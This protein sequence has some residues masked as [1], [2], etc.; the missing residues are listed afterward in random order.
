MPFGNRTGP[1]GV[2]PMT[3]RAAG[4]CAGHG[5]PGSTNL[6]PGRGFGDGFGRGRGLRGRGGARRGWRHMFWATGLPG[7]MRCA[8]AGDAPVATPNPEMEKQFVQQRADFLQ[9]QMDAIQKRLSALAS[10][11]A[12]KE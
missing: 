1:V 10:R 6:V 11:E 2:G 12:P 3:G 5:A 9:S 7:W 4:Y 8:P